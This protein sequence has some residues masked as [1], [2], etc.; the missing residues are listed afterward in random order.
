MSIDKSFR[1]LNRYRCRKV[2]EQLRRGPMSVAEIHSRLNIGT[3]VSVSQALALLLEAGLVTR[4]RQGRNHFYQ[5][6]PPGFTELVSYI[7]GFQ[8]QP[9]SATATDRGHS[10]P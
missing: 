8:P 10:K 5:L 1:A 3:R 7:K 6:R 2:L 9:A 4:R